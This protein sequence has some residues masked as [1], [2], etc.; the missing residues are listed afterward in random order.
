MHSGATEMLRYNHCSRYKKTRQ[1]GHKT[2]I[3]AVILVHMVGDFSESVADPPEH[4]LHAGAAQST[5]SN[6]P[7]AARRR[8]TKNPESHS[9]EK[10]RILILTD[11]PSQQT[12][13]L[14]F[15][16]NF[17]QNQKWCCRCT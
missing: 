15:G 10:L 17:F 11:F 2:K 4:P 7:W 6:W 9:P 5:W 3:Y 14:E 1:N 16:I 8:T 13:I 12:T